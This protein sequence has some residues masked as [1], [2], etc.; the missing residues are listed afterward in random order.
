MGV[1]TPQGGREALEGGSREAKNRKN[2]KF[3]ELS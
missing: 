2:R 3:L 1:A